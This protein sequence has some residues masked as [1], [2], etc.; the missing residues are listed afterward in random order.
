L[1]RKASRF[2]RHQFRRNGDLNQYEGCWTA[3]ASL[4]PINVNPLLAGGSLAVGAMNPGHPKNENIQFWLTRI[5]EEY[6][7]LACD[8]S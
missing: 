1:S 4:L 6:R 3:D 2:C 5:V 7:L 8:G